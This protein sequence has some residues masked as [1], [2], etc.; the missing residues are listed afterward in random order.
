MKR[1][2]ILSLLA[3]LVVIPL[4][5]QQ[6]T[7]GTPAG[8]KPLIDSVGEGGLTVRVKVP[9]RYYL[10]GQVVRAQVIAVNNST[11]PIEIQSR[12]A[13]LAKIDLRRFTGIRWETFK[14][15]PQAAAMVI[16]PW[17]LPPGQSR[18]FDLA[19]TVGEDWPVAET[20][21]LRGWLNGRDDLK[22]TVE[23]EVTPSE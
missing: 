11:E 21:R 22:P 12:S 2:L 17:T 13:A 5:C 23:I 20:I 9:Q 18:V 16:T 7:E 14:R 6:E 8:T 3:A 10:P 15:Y 19:L 1:N 4:A